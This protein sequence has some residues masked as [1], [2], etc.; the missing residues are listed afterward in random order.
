MLLTLRCN[1]GPPEI[2]TDCMGVVNTAQA[3][4]G[5]ALSHKNTTARIWKEIIELSGGDLSDLRKNLTWMPSHESIDDV[6]GLS[7]SNGRLVTVAEWRANQLADKLAKRGAASSDIR[8]ACE[9]IIKQAGNAL[10]YHAAQL[11]IV[12]KAANM[13]RVD[14]TDKHGKLRHK[15]TRD[16]STIDRSRPKAA[17]TAAAAKTAAEA[18]AEV[19]ANTSEN[20]DFN[21]TAQ[22]PTEPLR[23]ITTSTYASD[24][25]SRLK[26]EAAKRKAADAT[27]TNNIVRDLARKALPSPGDAD[28]RMAAL[29]RRLGFPINP[30]N[31]GANSSGCAS[32]PP[33]TVGPCSFAP[34][35]AQE[36]TAAQAHSADGTATD[37]GQHDC[38]KGLLETW[39]EEL[40][41]ADPAFAE[42]YDNIAPSALPDSAVG[43]ADRV[44][45]SCSFALGSAQ[46][47][48]RFTSA[49]NSSAG[50]IQKAI[51]L[52]DAATMGGALPGVRPDVLFSSSATTETASSPWAPSVGPDSAGS[53]R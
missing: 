10:N 35:S 25:T 6:V 22:P 48:S 44:G 18:P 3:G 45:A 16:S 29:R 31:P 40:L 49:M 17:T 2:V 36:P 15:F 24:K 23:H 46:T 32:S 41:D 19:A 1:T 33:P 51:L 11:G 43:S 28:T 37:I 53:L 7:K 14:F 8:D 26:R 5:A 30:N 21:T 20:Y 34:C 52:P 47:S 4:A 27:C 50:D 12:T 9:A 13:H 38:S 39:L 42:T